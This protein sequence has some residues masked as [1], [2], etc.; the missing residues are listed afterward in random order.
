METAQIVRQRNVF[1][2]LHELPSYIGLRAEEDQHRQSVVVYLAVPASS[3][4]QHLEAFMLD[5]FQFVSAVSQVPRN[6]HVLLVLPELC[7]KHRVG[8]FPITCDYKQRCEEAFKQFTCVRVV[9]A[10]KINVCDY[11]GFAAVDAGESE[12][13]SALIHNAFHCVPA[14][15]ENIL[16]PFVEG[17]VITEEQRVVIR[18]RAPDANSRFDRLV[19]LQPNNMMTYELKA[20]ADISTQITDT[21]KMYQVANIIP[22]KADSGA[23]AVV[24]FGVDVGA[25]CRELATARYK[26]GASLIPGVK[27]VR[28][29]RSISDKLHS[30]ETVEELHSNA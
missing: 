29:M 27:F 22:P 15:E 4:I 1:D 25:K 17:E 26:K 28:Y 12:Y 20:P 18:L 19:L 5:L 23:R 21:Y 2:F 11:C 9:F 30:V 8:P 24:P 14:T 16:M 13:I 6:V 3:A 10:E 7:E